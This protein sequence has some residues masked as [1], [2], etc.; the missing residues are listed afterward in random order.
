VVA[1][2]RTEGDAEEKGDDDRGEDQRSEVLFL[3]FDLICISS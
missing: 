1:A 3:L 2:V